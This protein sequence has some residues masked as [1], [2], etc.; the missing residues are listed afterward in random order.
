MPGARQVEVDT[1]ETLWLHSTCRQALNLED[2]RKYHFQGINGPKFVLDHSSH[3][4]PWPSGFEEC[5]KA[6]R[7]ECLRRRCS[8]IKNAKKRKVCYENRGNEKKCKIH[9]KTKCEDSKKFEKYAAWL[10]RKVACGVNV[11]KQHL[12]YR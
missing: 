6:K 3:I 1:K 12:K 7:K 4:E 11:C 2:G 10:N 8:A 5:E 9:A